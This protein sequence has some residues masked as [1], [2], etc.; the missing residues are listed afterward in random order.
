MNEQARYTTQLQAGTGLIEE[1]QTLLSLWKEG[2][3]TNE[4]YKHA[5]ESGEFANVTARRL[6]NIVIEGFSPRYL[7]PRPQPAAWLKTLQRRAD[8]LKLNQLFYQ[9]SQIDLLEQ[10]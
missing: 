8:F 4:L 9:C 1:T 5:L 7:N 10:H 6:R 2:M 3:T